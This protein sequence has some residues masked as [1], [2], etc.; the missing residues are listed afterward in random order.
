VRR[1][2]RF[3]ARAIEQLE[4][5]LAYIAQDDPAAAG[6]L[7]DAIHKRLGLLKEYPLSGRMLPERGRPGTRE[8]VVRPYRIV[9]RITE[10]EVY[11]VAV[12]HGRRDMRR[13]L[14]EDHEDG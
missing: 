10:E 6:R 2:L 1:R 3:S 12:A 8:V 14:D 7:C 13:V 9:Y 11:V 5:A 4:D